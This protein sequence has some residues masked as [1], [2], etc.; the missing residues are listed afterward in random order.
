MD[1]QAID[2]TIE[3]FGID[4]EGNFEGRSIPNRMH[5]RG[6]LRRPPMI[7]ETRQ[8][9]LAERSRRPRPGLDDKVL[10]EWNAL[11]SSRWPTPR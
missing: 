1:D 4:D 6:Q 10:T 9:L 11:F 5:S 3:W 8:R 7:E 2:L